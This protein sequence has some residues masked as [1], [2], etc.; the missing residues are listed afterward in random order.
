MMLLGRAS[1]V[2]M[3]VVM[4]ALLALVRPIAALD[5]SPSAILTSPAG[6]D[7]KSVTIWGT[8]TNLRKP[9]SRRGN[10]YY[11]VDLNDGKR[12]IR[13]FSFGKA[14]CREGAATV[15]GTFEQV[16]QVGR[17]T[18]RNEVTATRVTCR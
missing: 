5:A 15:E 16:K 12:T 2:I 9:V 7:G 6:F 1:L 13:V 3:L 4:L 10:P 17:L 14:P 18:F 8:I 11:T